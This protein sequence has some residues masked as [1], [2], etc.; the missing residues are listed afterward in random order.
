MIKK[1]FFIISLTSLVLSFLMPQTK[2]YAESTCYGPG[3]AVPKEDC[4]FCDPFTKIQARLTCM[5][6][7]GVSFKEQKDKDD[8]TLGQN[9]SDIIDGINK[10]ILEEYPDS[11]FLEL[12]DGNPGALLVSV[13]ETDGGAGIN[14]II[15]LAVAAATTGLGTN[16]D[17]AV[18]DCGNPWKQLPPK[19][20]PGQSFLIGFMPKKSEP[21]T[22]TDR[23]GNKWYEFNKGHKMDEKMV[24]NQADRMRNTYVQD[25]EIRL[26]KGTPEAN[27]NDGF[28][29]KYNSKNNS[30]LDENLF[31]QKMQD[32]LDRV[33]KGL[34]CSGDVGDGG[35][36]LA[37][38]N[39]MSEEQI[40]CYLKKKESPWVDTAKDLKAAAVAFNVNP[41]FLLAI[42]GQESTWGK[43]NG[44]SSLSVI[45][46][47]PGNVKLSESAANSNGI[48][49]TGR[50]SQGHTMFTTMADGWKGLAYSLRSTWLD[51]GASSLQEINHGNPDKGFGGYAEDPDW[52]RSLETFMQ[53]AMSCA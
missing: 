19:Q 32:I 11:P 7:W 30:V 21:P 25:Y 31:A 44:G 16:G 6:M 37:N 41:A 45:N 26:L 49:T 36:D 5:G 14:P 9:R 8:P 43:A 12:N 18:T 34:K 51:R 39:S 13:S 38:A 15:L 23:N 1:T 42:A 10:Y 17:S 46:N 50:D 47:N 4:T 24:Y 52:W 20:R 22:C 35:G 29:N 48:N 53:E 3:G 2:L 40:S 33:D 27:F 28:I